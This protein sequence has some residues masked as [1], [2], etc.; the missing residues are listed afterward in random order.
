[1]ASKGKKRFTVAQAMLKIA[2]AFAQGGASGDEDLTS[3]DED[4]GG[5]ERVDDIND[6]MSSEQ[7]EVDSDDNEDSA[8]RLVTM[9][10]LKT[11]LSS[12]LG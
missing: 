8:V 2:S 7:S 9:V 4:Y 10:D 6:V 12:W 11:N 3:E 5:V 1:M